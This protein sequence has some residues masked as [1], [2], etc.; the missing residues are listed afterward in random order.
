[1]NMNKMLRSLLLVVGLSVLIGFIGGC[2]KK[3][4]RAGEEKRPPMEGIGEGR[5]G[6]EGVERP[7]GGEEMVKKAPEEMEF[8]SISALKDIY[9]DFDKSNIKP[10]E[11]EV[12]NKNGEWLKDNPN[13]RVQIEGHCDER[14]TNEYNIALG[15]RRAV[16]ARD[17]L[18][19]LGISSERLYT[20]SYGEEKP[21]C[22]E[23]NE[24][25]WWQNRRAH[26][27]VGK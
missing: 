10:S 22:T 12:L 4:I 23:Q 6:E 8:V 24:S 17:Y 9:F 7:E 27:L 25:C 13:V 26:F 18:L 19:S 15:E 20:V 14:G 5:I 11:R 3:M 21:A 1:M 2:T 16:S